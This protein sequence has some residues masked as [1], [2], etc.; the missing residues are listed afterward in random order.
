MHTYMLHV[1]SEKSYMQVCYIHINACALHKMYES[2]AAHTVILSGHTRVL[3]TRYQKIFNATQTPLYLEFKHHKHTCSI[4]S[5]TI[6]FLL[7]NHYFQSM[8]ISF[9]YYNSWKL[10]LKFLNKWYEILILLHKIFC[11]VMSTSKGLIDHEKVW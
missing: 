11:A 2:V 1:C 7:E 9:C 6:S 10:P 3:S 5:N 8:F 4:L